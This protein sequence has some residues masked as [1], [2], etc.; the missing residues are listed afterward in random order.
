MF[1][2]E[3]YS[4]KNDNGTSAIPHKFDHP[5]FQTWLMFIGESTCLI[6]LFVMR[7]RERKEREKAIAWSA[8]V[9]H[10]PPEAPESPRVF[11]WILLIPTCCDLLGTSLAGIGL[12]YVDA[13]VWQM[14]RGAIIVFAGILSRVFLKRKLKAIHWLG[15]FVTMIGLVL[16]GCSSV[17][18]NKNSQGSK[19]ALGIALILAGQLVSASQMVLEELFLKKR[20]FPPLQVVG[21][22]G[23]YGTLLMTF[24][25]LPAMYFVPGDDAHGSYENSL[26]ALV[27]MGNNVEL[28]VMCLLYLISIAFYN[29][30][31]LAI[32][33][34][35]TAVHRT[36]ID[37]C[38]TI[39]VWLAALFIYY[40]VD[41]SFG[42]PFDS[43]YGLLQIDGFAFLLIGT[44]LYNQ[45][46]VVPCM[47][48]CSRDQE[49]EEFP[50]PVTPQVNVADYEES[51]NSISDES[52]PLLRA[53]DSNIVYS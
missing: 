43:N 8:K 34:S 42:E 15:M 18:K 52:D 17:F 5:W 36:L 14:L 7:R 12:I 3:G 1:V 2:S 51:Y 6:G 31:G 47:P 25:V 49:M 21:M 23:A 13:S 16:V 11:Q 39:I 37:A 50:S 20:N 27:Q 33:R 22:E 35:L 10:Q 32:T 53:R 4:Y 24:V 48:W 28:L 38:R 44:A 41:K 26:D 45:L 19:A 9:G 40:V 30:F 46:M 29:F